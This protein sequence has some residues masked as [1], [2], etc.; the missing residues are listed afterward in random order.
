MK[1]KKQ[2]MADDG[3]QIDLVRDEI[4]TT[5]P[6]ITLDVPAQAD[7]EF[8]ARAVGVR[9]VD[10]QVRATRG[11]GRFR[12]APEADIP[13]GRYT[14]VVEALADTGSRRISEPLELPFIVVATAAKIPDR[15]RIESFVRIRLGARGVERLGTDS[16]PGGEYI[17]FVKATDRRSG[18]PV[19]LAFDQDGRQVDGEARLAEHREGAGFQARQGPPCPRRCRALGQARRW[20]SRRR[21]ARYR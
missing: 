20:S 7:P 10:G 21:L 13:P 6:T 16:V 19:A 15:A 3:V 8:V 18:E 14:L 17:D 1:N 9:G 4:L 5:H 12:W 11:K 2:S